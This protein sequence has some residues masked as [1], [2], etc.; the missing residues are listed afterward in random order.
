MWDWVKDDNGI[1]TYKLKELASDNYNTESIILA[2]EDEIYFTREKA[3]D[4]LDPLNLGVGKLTSIYYKLSEFDALDTIICAPDEEIRTKMMYD[5]HTKDIQTTLDEDASTRKINEILDTILFKELSE[6]INEI[7]KDDSYFVEKQSHLD[8]DKFTR[9]KD[10]AYA[11]SVSIEAPLVET[12]RQGA[13]VNFSST[14]TVTRTTTKIGLSKLV[15]NFRTTD[16]TPTGVKF[17]Y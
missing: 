1:Y 2:P 17:D 7:P 16:F 14:V 5:E 9:T 4:F 13:E 6:D 15:T 11:L 8:D 3:I 10:D 12:V